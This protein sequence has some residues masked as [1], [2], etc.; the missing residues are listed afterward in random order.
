LPL[1]QRLGYELLNELSQGMQGHI[2]ESKCLRLLR[3]GAE[4]DITDADGMDALR[5]AV[6]YNNQLDGVGLEKLIVELASRTKNPYKKDED[7]WT[8]EKFAYRIDLLRKGFEKN[9]HIDVLRP[10]A[11]EKPRIGLKNLIKIGEKY[12]LVDVYSSAAQIK[13]DMLL[14]SLTQPKPVNQEKCLDLVAEDAD[15]DRLGARNKISSVVLAV[16]RH[17][18]APKEK[19]LDR[20][21]PRLVEKMK[22]KSMLK[23]AFK[24][25]ERANRSDAV[26]LIEQGLVQ[27]PRLRHLYDRKEGWL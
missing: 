9:P 25:A 19:G 3:Q 22:S 14:A 7:G 17:C 18:M 27:N 16:A 12:K 10:V 1:A 5:L 13:G 21:I 23:Q 26:M 20:L 8:I 4:C 6:S 2:S 15:V 11:E 24:V